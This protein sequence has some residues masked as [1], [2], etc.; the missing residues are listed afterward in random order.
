MLDLPAGAFA[1]DLVKAM[2]GHVI[3]KG[4]AVATFGR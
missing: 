4:E 1:T 3:Q 2:K